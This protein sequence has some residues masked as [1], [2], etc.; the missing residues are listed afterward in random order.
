MVAGEVSASP[1]TPHA[2]HISLIDRLRSYSVNPTPP[3]ATSWDNGA[4]IFQGAG[5]TD[6]VTEVELCAFRINS[7]GFSGRREQR[8]RGGDERK[9]GDGNKHWMT[10]HG[11]TLDNSIFRKIAHRVQR[12]KRIVARFATSLAQNAGR[13]PRQRIPDYASLHPS[14]K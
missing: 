5:A 11:D 2:L 6:F 13:S 10:P 14:Y 4:A 3:P 8:E 7:L 12:G 1:V 9:F